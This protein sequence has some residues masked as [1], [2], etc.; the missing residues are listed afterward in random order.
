M[1]YNAKY[2]HGKEKLKKLEFRCKI[3]MFILLRALNI[4]VCCLQVAY[5]FLLPYLFMYSPRIVLASNL[6]HENG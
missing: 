4:V 5:Y 6:N 2:V 1:I 3:F